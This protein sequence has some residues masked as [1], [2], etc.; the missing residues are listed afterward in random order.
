[1]P[2]GRS[3]LRS[4]STGA[5][6]ESTDTNVVCWVLEKPKTCRWLFCFVLFVCFWF[7]CCFGFLLFLF[8]LFYLFLFLLHLFCFSYSSFFFFFFFFFFFS[9]FWGGGGLHNVSIS[10][11]LFAV[12]TKLYVWF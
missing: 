3:F 9:F 6:S 5:R 2:L 7:V 1:M 10:Q 11:S 4:K 12:H 8:V